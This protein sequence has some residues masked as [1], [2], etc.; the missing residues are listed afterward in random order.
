M[1]NGAVP[2]K[3]SFA[4]QFPVVRGDGYKGIGWQEIEEIF[5]GGI[6]RVNDSDLPPV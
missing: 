2:K 5:D 6:D 4:K 1:L 3:T